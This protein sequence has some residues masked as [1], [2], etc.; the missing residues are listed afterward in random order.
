VLAVRIAYRIQPPVLHLQ[1]H[2]ALLRMPRHEIRMPVSLTPSL[3]H[4]KPLTSILSRQ[5]ARRQT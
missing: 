2:N 1:H 5:R 4:V 3:S